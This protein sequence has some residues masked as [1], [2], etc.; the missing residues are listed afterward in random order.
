MIIFYNKENM[1]K[2]VRLIQHTREEVDLASTG[3]KVWAMRML[4][5]AT[6]SDKEPMFLPIDIQP[7]LDGDDD[8]VIKRAKKEARK[9]FVNRENNALINK[10]K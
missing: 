9:F 7:L 5:K 6:F 2:Q 4:F 8:N 1:L 3:E 10:D